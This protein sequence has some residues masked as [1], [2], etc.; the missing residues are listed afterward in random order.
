MG[1]ISRVAFLGGVDDGKST[2]LGRTLVAAGALRSDQLDDLA[3]ASRRHRDTDVDLSLITDGLRHERAASITLDV[4][5]RHLVIG[6]RRVLLA[7]CPGHRSLTA[8][9]FT[10]VA[11][12]QVAVVLVDA[13]RGPT[14][15][16][17]RHLA[18]SRLAG[19]SS[20]VVCVNK[21][22]LVGFDPHVFD[23]LRASTFAT[24]STLSVPVSVVLPVSALTDCNIS[25]PASELSWFDGPTLFD[26]LSSEPTPAQ[27]PGGHPLRL[28]V[29]FA[30]GG[31]AFGSVACGEVA[32]GDTLRV[33]PRGG[34][35]RVMA[36]STWRDRRQH[37]AS[38]AVRVELSGAIPARGDV[39]AA[40]ND[41]PLTT[42]SLAG[43]FCWFSTSPPHPDAPVVV[44]LGPQRLPAR[45]SCGAVLDL[46]RGAWHLGSVEPSSIV[47][48][49]LDLDTPAWVDTA[50]PALRRVLVSDPTTGEVLAAGSI[51]EG[52]R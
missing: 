5:Y 46:E 38:G 12:A 1:S 39:L 49:F 32:V 14:E 48:L 13:S 40:P 15:Q 36:V 35:A 16:T 21:M 34:S 22:D 37:A 19:V 8:N 30:R 26:A 6:D 11:G 7:D 45:A 4:A 42:T 43:E 2:L 17:W 31:V 18:L 41:P 23:A 33:L 27:I 44:Q 50:V 28:P 20:V 25:A 29:Q 51:R 52:R 47:E 10:G 24:A 3:E 9:A